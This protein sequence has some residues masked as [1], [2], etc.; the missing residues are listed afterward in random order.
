MRTN[1]AEAGAPTLSASTYIP[2]ATRRSG[3]TNEHLRAARPPEKYSSQHR[4]LFS[5]GTS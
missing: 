4:I 5:S 3:L 2:R 1:V